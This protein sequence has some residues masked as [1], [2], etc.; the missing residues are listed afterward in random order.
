MPGKTAPDR[1]TGN[2]IN[3]APRGRRLIALVIIA[4]PTGDSPLLPTRVNTIDA[5]HFGVIA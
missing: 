3:V 1:G 4:T 5:R 2:D